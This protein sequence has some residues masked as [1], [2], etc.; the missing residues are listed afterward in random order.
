MIDVELINDC[1][2][3]LKEKYA[4]LE[5]VALCN[6]EKVL[7]AFKKNKVALRHFV[8][9]S[10]YGY[11]DEGKEVL[12]S[13]FADIF[14]AESAV[15]SPNIV[16]G[17]HALALC[18][19]GILRNGDDVLSIS[20]MP[21]D[22]LREV[23]CGKNNG[24]LEEYGVTFRYIDLK[25]GEF[26][27]TAIL[28]AITVKKPKMVY[29]QRSR[30][31]EWRNA[32]SIGQ[33]ENVVSFLRENGFDGCIMTDNCYGEFVEK[34]EPTDVG[35]NIVA[36]SLIKNIGGGLAPTGGYVAGDKKYVDAVLTR[37]TA[38]SISGEVGSYYSG[39]QYFFQG[40]FM[41]P[42]TVLQALKGSLL[43]GAV[44]HKLGYETSPSVNDIPRDIIR[45][46]KFDKEEELVAFIQN[47]QSNS[48]V[49]SNVVLE[50]W[51]MPGYEDKVIMAAGTFVQ[52]ASI[53][54]SADAPVKPPYI[55]YMQGGLTY[56]HC[57][58]ALKNLK[59]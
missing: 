14:G 50:P 15:C 7:D 2:K 6:Q 22:T 43:F 23:F 53:E 48:P 38:P 46:V 10:G 1:E 42:H 12:C 20:G 45:A 33:I 37:M 31:Y 26:D 4:Y 51:D 57:K 29:I 30:G 8:G 55:A 35:V 16:S 39:Y 28:N 21:Y 13:V 44:L 52:G 25:N 19:Y 9:T 32:L 54:M 49:D 59:L 27:K 58:I 41:A 5:E 3:Q 17:T 24:S 56:E 36:G 34:K 47:I 11:G 40:L 18:L